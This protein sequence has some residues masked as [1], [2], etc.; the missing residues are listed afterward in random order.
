[1]PR[2]VIRYWLPPLLWTA[3]I[4][5]ASTDW[6]SAGHSAP[7]LA[8]L[9]EAV[10]GRPLPPSSFDA[11]HFFVR[12]LGHLTEYGV[13]GALLFRAMRAGDPTRW[14]ARWAVGGVL[15]AAIVGALDEWHQMFV[16]S[17]TA[18]P[19]DVAL[20]TLGAV[21]AQLLIRVAQVLF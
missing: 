10:L 1:M 14:N 15:I 9:I 4:F 17:R 7:L 13:L 2:S 11:L 21:L 18:S 19:A 16:P 3:V 8:R 20:D 5:A 6:F 12:K